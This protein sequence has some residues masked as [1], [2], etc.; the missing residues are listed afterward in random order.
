[1]VSKVATT[2]EANKKL[3]VII[4]INIKSYNVMGRHRPPHLRLGNH[5]CVVQKKITP[6]VPFRGS[7]RWGLPNSKLLVTPM[8]V[9][10]YN[11][12]KEIPDREMLNYILATQLQILRRLDFIGKQIFDNDE[13]ATHEDDRQKRPVHGKNQRV[14]VPRGH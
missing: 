11:S 1:M 12:L 5:Y 9:H 10:D 8:S 4:S 6:R 13:P 7:P 3:S 14:H 2:K